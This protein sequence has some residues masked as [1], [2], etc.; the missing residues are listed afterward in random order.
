MVGLC[1]LTA[2]FL[3]VVLRGAFRMAK[4]R[5]DHTLPASLVEIIKALN[6]TGD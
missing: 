6:A 1:E 5:H 2:V 4:E 3:T